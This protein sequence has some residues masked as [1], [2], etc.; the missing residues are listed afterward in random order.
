MGKNHNH[1]G[2][3]IVFEGIDGAG[4]TTQAQRY[5]EHLTTKRR[6]VYVT[7][8]PSD[9]PIGSLLRLGLAGRVRL[10]ASNQ[11]QAMALLFAAD[12]LDHLAHEIEPY[13]RDGYIVLCDRYDLSS[14][15]YQTATARPDT[16]P[17]GDFAE[18]VRSL[19]RFAL[20]PDATVILEVSPERAKRRRRDRLGAPE[21][22]EQD[23]LQERLARLYQQ[24]EKLLP[25]DKLLRID[26][27]KSIDE[28]AI[29]VQEALSPVV[30]G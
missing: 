8:Q 21:L 6:L 9:G 30:G 20:R 19:N 5:A 2:H 4:T 18:W 11:A 17:N 25:E 13:L 16:N 24:A 23:D 26:G 28:V 27:D 22:F 29:A 12:R 14:I 3:L 1:D 7:R 10:G 15:T